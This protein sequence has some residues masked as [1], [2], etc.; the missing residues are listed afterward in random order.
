MPVSVHSLS[1][2]T[3]VP[4]SVQDK[5]D[6]LVDYMKTILETHKA[7]LNYADRYRRETDVAV[8]RQDRIAVMGDPDAGGT[9]YLE[10][11]EVGPTVSQMTAHVPVRTRHRF[12]ASFWYGYRDDQVAANSS[13]AAFNTMVEGTAQA[14]PGLLWALRTVHFIQTTTTAA[15]PSRLLRLF[16]QEDDVKD[17]VPLDME[18]RELAH[19]LTFTID[20]SDQ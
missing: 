1:L 6:A 19:F 9:Y 12:R 11:I 16:L 13:Q 20:V 7:G 3:P 4:V 10:V 18:G 17:V 15:A 8:D 2:A 14:L 5:S